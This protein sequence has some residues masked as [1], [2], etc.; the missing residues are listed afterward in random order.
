MSD[1]EQDQKATSEQINVRLG[2]LD[3]WD[4][5]VVL[6]ALDLALPGCL[7]ARWALS[8][9]TLESCCAHRRICAIGL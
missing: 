4:A 7:V 6:D 2:L 3:A 5:R 8:T 1:Q 9:R